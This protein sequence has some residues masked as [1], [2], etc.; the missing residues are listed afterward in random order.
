MGNSL[1]TVPPEKNQQMRICFF[2]AGFGRREAGSGESS[3]NTQGIGGPSVAA[4]V[5]LVVAGCR[6]FSCGMRNAF[7][8]MRKWKNRWGDST[9]ASHGESAGKAAGRGAL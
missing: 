1:T 4:A 8:S 3:Q 5:V 6:Y 9:R 2:R 7:P